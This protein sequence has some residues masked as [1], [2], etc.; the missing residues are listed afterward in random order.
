MAKTR[1]DD[2]FE[3]HLVDNHIFIHNKDV[4][5][6]NRDEIIRK[7][8]AHRSEL[9]ESGLTNE[10][11]QRFRDRNRDASEDSTVMST[12]V[13]MITG[14]AN[15]TTA[16]NL[17]MSNLA[18]L[19]DVSLTKPVPSCCEGLLPLEIDFQ[20]RQD[21]GRY[22]IPTKKPI[23]L[24]LPN[25]FLE[26]LA[27]DWRVAKR[28]GCYCGTLGARGVYKLRSYVN[29]DTALDNRAYTVIA[30]YCQIGTLQLYTIHPA[31]F[32]NDDMGYYMTLL[33]A[34]VMTDNLESFRKG[35]RALRNARDW[36]IEQRK[37][38]ADSANAQ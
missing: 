38:L 18:D 25:F 24:C 11:F 1:L 12:V 33:G 6:E 7:M 5:P 20:I 9:E 19:T 13:P 32:G 22:I 4:K 30:T 35:V 23:A 31:K 36:A 34:F 26:G 17:S 14:D 8:A 27:T 16:N 29:L 37:N 28:R 3:I 15:T 10:K 2:A 21:L